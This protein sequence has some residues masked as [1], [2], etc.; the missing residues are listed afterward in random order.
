MVVNSDIFLLQKRI[1]MWDNNFDIIL[2]Y[3]KST[4]FV[5]IKT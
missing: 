1:S 2:F 4:V 5:Y 3:L